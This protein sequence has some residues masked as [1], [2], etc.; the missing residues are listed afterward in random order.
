MMKC[1]YFSR[2][3]YY[4]Y[5]NYARKKHSSL[6][7]YPFRRR[8][9]S[10][11]SVYA[12]SARTGKAVFA[13]LRGQTANIT[14]FTANTATLPVLTLSKSGNK[15]IAMSVVPVSSSSLPFM[16]RHVHA[17]TVPAS[18]RVWCKK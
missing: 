14:D 5:K 16:G 4:I 17:Q 11:I 13:Q 12:I 18:A 1:I 8:T 2:M 9:M 15:V 6:P 10:A 3:T 7:R